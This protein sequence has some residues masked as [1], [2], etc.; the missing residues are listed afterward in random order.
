MIDITKQL[1]EN[2]TS[3]TTEDLKNI[4]SS[5]LSIGALIL[6]VLSYLQARKSLF[7]PKTTEVFKLQL[8]EYR[9][10]L[11]FLNKETIRS[12]FR[13]VIV[14]NLRLLAMDYQIS[15]GQ[16]K[17]EKRSEL[18]DTSLS[19]TVTKEMNA[20]WHGVG[21]P[22]IE[23]WDDHHLGSI[24]H[25]STKLN[26][27]LALLD[28]IESSLFMNKTIKNIF[29]EIQEQY[30]QCLT[31]LYKLIHDYKETIKT[32]ITVKENNCVRSFWVDEIENNFIKSSEYTKFNSSIET[33]KKLIEDEIKI[34]KIMQ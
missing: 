24:Q 18:T 34:D 21:I 9:T 31:R 3:Y 15:V 8:N 22:S 1:W 16:I 33:A 10:A 5:L 17:A 11:E 14:F 2:L 23:D 12:E 32:T 30:H 28:Q 7:S 27:D 20:N 19:L 4:T 29:H 13:H 6:G 26:E 25:R